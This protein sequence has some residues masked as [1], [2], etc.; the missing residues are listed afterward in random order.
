MYLAL[1]YVKT[2]HS[3]RRQ[4]KKILTMLADEMNVQLQFS[5]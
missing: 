3:N 5:V 4:L 1:L 2:L